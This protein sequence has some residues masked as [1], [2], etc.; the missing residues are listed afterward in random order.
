MSKYFLDKEKL[1]FLIGAVLFIFYA[2]LGFAQQQSSEKRFSPNGARVETEG[3]ESNS[4]KVQ[5]SPVLSGDKKQIITPGAIKTEGT[6]VIPST[7]ATPEGKTPIVPGKISFVDFSGEMKISR[8]KYQAT[9]VPASTP[10]LKAWGY[11]PKTAEAFASAVKVFVSDSGGKGK[12]LTVQVETKSNQIFVAKE[13][14]FS[15]YDLVKEKKDKDTLAILIDSFNAAGPEWDFCTYNWGNKYIGYT[16]FKEGSGTKEP[17]KIKSL[18]F[19]ETFYPFAKEKFDRALVATWWLEV[20]RTAKKEDTNILKG[21][22]DQLFPV[23][24]E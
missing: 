18:L 15:I 9:I 4:K 8:G 3:S 2:L 16:F 24:E 5:S 22:A 7:K 6:D 12:P 11:Q 17:I 20:A 10:I 14:L 23:Y 1:A 13:T 19:P 21:F